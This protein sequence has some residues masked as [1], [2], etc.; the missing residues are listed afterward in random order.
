M[1]TDRT[2][3]ERIAAR[4]LRGAAENPLVGMSQRQASK[5]V[6]WLIGRVP[7]SGMHRDEYWRPVQ[8]IW[9]TFN[10]VGLDYALDGS[11]YAKDDEGRPSSKTWTFTVYY[12]NDK[13]KPATLHGRVVA[14][15][16][17][18]V[19]EPLAVYDVDASVA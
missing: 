9:K 11:Q 12:V 19:S 4:A 2:M 8:A 7:T 16:A 13:G 3:S 6:N 18:P 1:T 5:H 14:A 15:G 10:D 17:G